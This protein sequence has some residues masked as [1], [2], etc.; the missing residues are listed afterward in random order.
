MNL[1]SK[2]LPSANLRLKI[3][4]EME[5][6]LEARFLELLVLRERVRAAEQSQA[7]KPA[8]TKVVNR[9]RLLLTP[10]DL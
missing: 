2:R 9:E 1:N 5:E 3:L 6:D 4:I 7:R 10:A 8:L